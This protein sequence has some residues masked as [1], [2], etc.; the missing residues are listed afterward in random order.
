M[1]LAQMSFAGLVKLERTLSAQATPSGGLW[2]HPLARRR[3]LDAIRRE[4]ADRLAEARATAGDP[5]LTNGYSGQRI[6]RLR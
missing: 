5:V 4:I 2:L 3:Q 6:R 1:T